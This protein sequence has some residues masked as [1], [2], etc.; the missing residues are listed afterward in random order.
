MANKKSDLDVALKVRVGVKSTAM[1]RIPMPNKKQ[2]NENGIWYVE[3][4][5]DIDGAQ[6]HIKKI[7]QV[8]KANRG[9]AGGD[10]HLDFFHKNQKTN[11]KSKPVK[12]NARCKRK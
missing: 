8:E 9:I 6:N 1:S 10:P 11:K 12:R 5:Q 4:D 3:H 7:K 2:Y